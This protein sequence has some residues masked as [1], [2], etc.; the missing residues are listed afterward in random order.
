MARAKADMT[1]SEFIGKLG[2]ELCRFIGRWCEKAVA[3][4]FDRSVNK[5]RLFIET[6]T[7]WHRIFIGKRCVKFESG[8]SGIFAD[9]CLVYYRWSNL[10]DHQ[11]VIGKF[12]DV[13]K[14]FNRDM[15]S[16]EKNRTRLTF[17]DSIQ[18][19]QM[20]HWTDLIS[21]R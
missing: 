2:K 21:K 12:V 4:R 13:I 1:K 19:Y 5:I 15:F 7:G 9:R 20:Q 16:S 8:S 3:V 10:D 14:G 17:Y 6:E 11:D 18:S